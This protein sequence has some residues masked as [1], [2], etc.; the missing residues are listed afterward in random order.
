MFVIN[1]P[2]IFESETGNKH[3]SPVWSLKWTD[4]DKGSQNG[5]EEEMEVIM[6]IS[7]DG[8]V[9][10]WMIRKGFESSGKLLSS[11]FIVKFKTS[12]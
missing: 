1:L 5:E 8:R 4:R 9:S 3:L 6:S 11:F 2:F 12:I 10:Q 7:T